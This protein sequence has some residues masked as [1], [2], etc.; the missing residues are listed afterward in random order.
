MVQLSPGNTT[1]RK[2]CVLNMWNIWTYKNG[3]LW[4][5]KWRKK[6]L[7]VSNFGFRPQILLENVPRKHFSLIFMHIFPDGWFFPLNLFCMSSKIKQNVAWHHQ[8]NI[9]DRVRHSK[10]SPGNSYSKEEI[11]YGCPQETLLYF[12]YFKHIKI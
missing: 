10:L 5:I 4:Y 8:V 7:A 6:V 1:F 11:W 12:F 9:S 2:K 3:N